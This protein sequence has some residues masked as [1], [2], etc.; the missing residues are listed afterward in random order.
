VCNTLEY[1]ETYT[2]HSIDEDSGNLDMYRGTAFDNDDTVRSREAAKIAELIPLFTIKQ[3]EALGKNALAM[4]SEGKVYEN[5]QLPI[6][7]D[8]TTTVP[9]ID[10]LIKEGAKEKD[11]ELFMPCPYRVLYPQE[12]N[13][14]L[15]MSEVSHRQSNYIHTTDWGSSTYHTWP[16]DECPYQS[17]ISKCEKYPEWADDSFSSYYDSIYAH[18]MRYKSVVYSHIQSCLLP[19]IH[20]KGGCFY[21][22]YCRVGVTWYRERAS[23]LTW[24]ANYYTYSPPGDERDIGKWSY[25]TTKKVYVSPTFLVS[26]QDIHYAS[27]LPAKFQSLVAASAPLATPRNITDA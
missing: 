8:Y 19:K 17:V 14:M 11:G 20:S 27:V 24:Y 12:E 10:A 3:R 6:R 26:R 25:N 22:I 23:K 1:H 4:S 13:A 18:L 21:D 15:T 5:D 16:I 2:K 9:L 7:R